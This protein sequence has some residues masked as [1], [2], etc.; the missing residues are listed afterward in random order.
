MSEGYL[1]EESFKAGQRRAGGRMSAAAS[2]VDADT[3]KREL[4]HRAESVCRHLLPAGKREGNEWHCGNLRG[5]PG[6]SLKINLSEG[7]WEDF[8]T[9]ER[10]SNILELWKQARG[11]DF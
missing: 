3:V 5:K 4:L 10:G 11:V 9:G 7:V 1:A 6:H 8:A 2:R